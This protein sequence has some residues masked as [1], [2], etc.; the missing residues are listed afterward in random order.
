MGMPINTDGRMRAREE[1]GPVAREPASFIQPV[2]QG[3]PM[4]SQFK[5]LLDRKPARLEPVYVAGYGCDRS[6]LCQLL[7]DASR[8]DIPGMQDMSTPKK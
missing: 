7:D 5:H 8:T 2:I 6:N 4:T 3:H 1:F